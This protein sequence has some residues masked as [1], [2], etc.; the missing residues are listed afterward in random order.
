MCIGA[1]P[2]R[3]DHSSIAVH[4]DERMKGHPFRVHA[5]M[6]SVLVSGQFDPGILGLSSFRFCM[7]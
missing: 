6:G 3:L 7:R 4:P 2:P 5:L 1:G